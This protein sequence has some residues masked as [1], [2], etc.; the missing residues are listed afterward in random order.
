[1]H[2]LIV[3]KTQRFVCKECHKNFTTRFKDKRRRHSLS[4]REEVVKRNIE[5]N[6]SFRAIAR[7]LGITA[8]T[9]LN[10]VNEFGHNCKSIQDVHREL[11]PSWSG[12]LGIDGKPIKIF[13]SEKMVLLASDKLTHDL[14]HLD[15]VEAESEDDCKKF[16]LTIRDNIRYPITGIISDFGKGRVWLDLIADLFPD[17]PH[18][19]C[20]V[21]FQRYV[22]QRIPKSKK[23]HYYAQNKFLRQLVAE[24]LFTDSFNDSEELFLRLKKIKTQFKVKYQKMIITSIENHYH[25][26]TTYF[27]NPDLPRDNNFVEN[28][29]KQL[30][31][32]LK[33]IDGFKN[34]DNAKN[35]LKL[36]SIF[37]RF[38][39]FTDSNY[40][41][42]N[43][44]SPLQLAGANVTNSDWLKYSQKPKNR[45]S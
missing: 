25:T 22:N 16:L 31:R 44:K 14:V 18:Q 4:F 26:L 11:R 5:E 43:G 42:K 40:E 41:Y 37:Y 27:H 28:I 45:P 7:R 17:I 10:W 2:A 15:L 1:M 30:N 29:V 19:T 9:A 39:P 33:Q 35:F 32:K 3:S 34:K 23:S 13:G 12:I 20:V 21:H 36:W 6:V 38:K 8:S 24:I